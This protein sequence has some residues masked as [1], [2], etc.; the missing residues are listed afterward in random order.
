MKSQ[1]KAILIGAGRGKRLMPYTQETPK[2]FAEVKGKR[3]LD[4]GLEALQAG[5][6]T[7]IV[8][9]GGY[10]MEKV[11][12]VYPKFSF[13]HNVDWEN[14]NVLFSLMC[15]E[16]YMTDGFVCAYSDILYR[17]EIIRSLMESQ[18]DITLVCD[19]AWR[20]RYRNR[21][22]HPESDGEKIAAEGERII[23][24]NRTME[25]EVALGEYIG[26]ARF[27]PK[28][29]KVLRMAFH[30]RKFKG[31]GG[32]FQEA[33]IF[34]KSY[35]IDL[36]QEMIDKGTALFLLETEGGYM[37]IDTNQD[38]MVAKKDWSP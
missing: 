8:F 10:R 30:Q 28:G 26:L 2:C 6:L 27:T 16:D 36:Y 38:F 29:A 25:N 31:N 12:A 34:K 3:I 33:K 9:I 13:C 4:W 5:G 18:H 7:D 35:L 11:Q 15:A 37:E 1:M 32:R 20:D 17:G 14:N 21:T 22:E 24:V 23:A 19:T